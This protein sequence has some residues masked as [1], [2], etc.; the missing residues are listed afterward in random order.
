MDVSA[1]PATVPTVRQ[2]DPNPIVR[3][4]H[5]VVKAAEHRCFR[6]VR[7]FNVNGRIDNEHIGAF[8]DPIDAM[9]FLDTEQ[10]RA[11]IVG[12]DGKTYADNWRR[13]EKRPA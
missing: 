10:G 8:K 1:G 2:A 7:M 4:Y 3:V 6:V 5:P 9:T 12:P 13:I 11:R